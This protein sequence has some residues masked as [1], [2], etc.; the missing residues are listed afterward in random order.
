MPRISLTD[1][2]LLLWKREYMIGICYIATCA[3]YTQIS[4]RPALYASVL[5]PST[6]T[7]LSASVHNMRSSGFNT[8]RP[9][10]WFTFSRRKWLTFFRRH[11]QI[12]YLDFLWFCILKIGSKG[13]FDRVSIGLG[14]VL[15]HDTK[16]HCPNH[17]SNCPWRNMTSPGL[18]E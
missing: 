8:L 18:S 2:F 16:W 13:L 17:N 6:Y 7:G 14:V 10:K 9:G 1:S 5:T 15:Y 4:S 3:L 11:L 12:Y